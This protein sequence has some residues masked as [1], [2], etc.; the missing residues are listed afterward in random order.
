VTLAKIA[1]IA[2]SGIRNIQISEFFLG[3]LGGL[4]ERVFFFDNPTKT[5]L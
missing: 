5:T 1:K 4:G 3:D 2:K